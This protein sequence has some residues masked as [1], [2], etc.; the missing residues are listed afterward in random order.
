MNKASKLF[1][2]ILIFGSA[3]TTFA[4]STTSN[5][6]QYLLIGVGPYFVP[7]YGIRGAHISAA[8]GQHLTDFSTKNTL[9]GAVYAEFGAKAMSYKTSSNKYPSYNGGQFTGTV[10]AQVKTDQVTLYFRNGFAFQSLEEKDTNS[11]TDNITSV[12]LV[13][14]LGFRH[15]YLPNLGY[16]FDLHGNMFRVVYYIGF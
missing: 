6:D 12:Q 2:F 3:I 1:L 11:E 4:Q 10:L 9:V 13:S 8:I 14:D 7:N 15:S 5:S 16:E